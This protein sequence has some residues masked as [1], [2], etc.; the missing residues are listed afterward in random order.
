[1][2]SEADP[3]SIKKVW[4]VIKCNNYN[5]GRSKLGGGAEGISCGMLQNLCCKKIHNLGKVVKARILYKKSVSTKSDVFP[6][7]ISDSSKGKGRR[8]S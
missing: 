1:M 6:Q 5:T 8:V 2:N 7:I 3:N 4:I